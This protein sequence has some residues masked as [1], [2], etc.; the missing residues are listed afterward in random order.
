M[1]WRLA[2]APDPEPAEKRAERM[3]ESR[4]EKFGKL[5]RQAATVQRKIEKL[6]KTADKK[7]TAAHVKKLEK[8]YKIGVY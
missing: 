7:S 6:N 2:K 8:E 4:N 5:L 3:I 1:V